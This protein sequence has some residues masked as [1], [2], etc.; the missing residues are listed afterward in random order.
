[1]THTGRCLSLVDG[2]LGRSRGTGFV[3]VAKSFT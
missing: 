1:M 3:V 2:N